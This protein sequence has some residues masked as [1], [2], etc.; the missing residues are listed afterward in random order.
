MAQ[1]THNIKSTGNGD[2]YYNCKLDAA[3]FRKLSVAF[4][5][6]SFFAR[7]FWVNL[8]IDLHTH[9]VYETIWDARANS[10]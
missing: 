9:S 8:F 3:T 2:I 1:H 7:S 5:P 10:S 4:L 6:E